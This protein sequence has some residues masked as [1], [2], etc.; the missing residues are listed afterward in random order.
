MQKVAAKVL[1]SNVGGAALG[2]LSFATG[3]PVTHFEG[4]VGS[5]AARVCSSHEEQMLL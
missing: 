4:S 2:H 3:L 5:G 1:I